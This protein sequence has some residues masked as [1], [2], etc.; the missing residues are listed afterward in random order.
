[1]ESQEKV[2][3]V[4]FSEQELQ[5]VFD[6]LQNANIRGSVAPILAVIMQKFQDTA[7]N[8]IFLN[9]QAKNV[10]NNTE[11][12]VFDEEPKTTE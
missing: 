7:R 6:C 1:M 2:F 12:V 11:N 4:Q 8:P 9:A 3:I 10:P 5:V